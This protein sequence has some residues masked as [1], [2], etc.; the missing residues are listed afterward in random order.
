MALLLKQEIQK[1]QADG[2]DLTEDQ[3]QDTA[4]SM[5]SIESIDEDPA[6]RPQPVPSESQA[7]ASEPEL[8]NQ[9]SFSQHS[10][11]EST[12]DELDESDRK[13]PTSPSMNTPRE[14][15]QASASVD[16]ASSPPIQ[17]VDSSV[18]PDTPTAQTKPG[19]RHAH[20]SHHERASTD[21]VGD[22]DASET[23]SQDG[24]SKTH[25]RKGHTI[26]N[27]EDSIDGRSRVDDQRRMK[28][29]NKCVGGW[30]G[31]AGTCLLMHLT[32]LNL[33][34]LLCHVVIGGHFTD[35]DAATEGSVDFEVDPS[36]DITANRLNSKG[37]DSVKRRRLPRGM[38]SSLRKQLSALHLML[39]AK[40]SNDE[41]DSKDSPLPD[42]PE[43]EVEQVEQQPPSQD[44]EINDQ[45]LDFEA[46]KPQEAVV[47]QVW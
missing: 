42:G 17:R 4:R 22:N 31:V 28:W 19:H 45:Q 38:D 25:P 7:P 13:S 18:Q 43:Q 27:S 37:R 11:P 36:K 41:P 34:R 40:K 8:I 5:Q 30:V 23:S 39:A 26:M 24:D 47:I 15:A 6:S 20:K 9:S 2:K 21:V 1:A 33:S 10:F 16:D 29:M 46:D 12:Q 35:T 14:Q 44:A 32:N 3:G